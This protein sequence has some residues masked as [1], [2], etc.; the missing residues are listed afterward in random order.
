MRQILKLSI[1]IFF[2]CL[3]P[4]AVASASSGAG[5]Q[6]AT[7]SGHKRVLILYSFNNNVPTTHQIVTGIND[8][9][10]RNNLR[11]ADF[12]HEYLDIAPPK[13]PSQRSTLRELLL[14]K[15]AGQQF[16]L[17]VTYSSEA[18]N[19]L[20]NEGKDLSPGTHCIALF[21]GQSK[22]VEDPRR[23]VT[24]IPMGLDPRGTL[25]LGLAL[26]PNTH[27]VLFVSG[28]KPFDMM[29]ENQARTEFAPWQG[30]LEFE[31]TSQVS[32]DDLMK[33]V[34]QLPPTTLII[35]SNVAS[36]I[37]G[38][39]FVPRDL[40]KTLASISNAPVLSMFSTQIDTGV[41]GGSMID[42]ELIGLM[43][44]NLMVGL[45]AGK[46]LTIETAPN[47]IRPMFNWKQIERWGLN[48]DRLPAESIFVN[49]PATLWGQYKAEVVAASSLML[50]LCTMTVALVI[51]NRRR[52]YAEM[53]VRETAVQLAEER[54]MLEE[55]VAERTENLSEALDFNETMLLNLPVPMGVYA[56]SGQC[57][58]ANDAYAQFVGAARETLLAQNFHKIASWKATSLL[59]D[60]LTAIKL[61]EPQQREAHVVTTFGKDVWFEYRIL[62][63]H[64]KGEVHLLIQFF[65]LT[66]RK[67]QQFELERRVVA[68]TAELATAKTEAESANMVKT[69][70]MANVSHEMRTPMNG[71]LGLADIGKRKIGKVS[72]DVVGGY[73]DK[74]FDSGMRL[75]KLIESLLSLAQDALN[76]QSGIQEDYLAMIEPESLAIQAIALMEVTA[77]KRQ[78]KI[79]LENTST[80][81]MFLGDGL[82]LRQVLENLLSNALIYSPEQTSVIVRIQDS[83]AFTDPPTKISIQ[84]IDQGCGIPEKELSAIFEPFYESSRTTTGAGGTGLGLSLA[85]SIIGRHKG[86]LTATNRPEGGAI[87]EITLPL[88]S[89]A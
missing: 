2:L 86:T 87:F 20:L 3:T 55:R 73:F 1:Y 35:F 11:S 81:P 30:K 69:R 43:I 7:G 74:I 51:Q 38:K 6:Q 22:D 27:K 31:Y 29:F 58:L 82:R 52:K 64:V 34:V 76:E 46:P 24:Y 70:F 56:E 78:Q 25:E 85:K 18:L 13:H 53:T 75:N 49:R 45:E 41:I 5:V 15:Y 79:V 59:G 48:P 71:I 37:T 60:C 83:P 54:D 23:R 65:D 84:V 42:M 32:V 67:V 68:R 12:V 63:T 77:A 21:G 50:I 36:D 14:Q 57:I 39:T 89:K 16:D 10:K 17:I 80:I 40:V 88:L 19:F 28:N 9:I 72:N 44:G 26:F 61:Q 4:F 47:Y 8:V 66:E 33:Q 62:P